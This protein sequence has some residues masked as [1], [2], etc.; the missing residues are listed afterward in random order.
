MKY[1]QSKGLLTGFLCGEDDDDYAKMKD[2]IRTG[3]Y[4]LVFL[5]P[6]HYSLGSGEKYSLLMYTKWQFKD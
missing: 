6:S 5:L 3:E 4:Q 1:F 2:G